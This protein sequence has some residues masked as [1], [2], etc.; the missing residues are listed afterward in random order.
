MADL[1]GVGVPLGL[2]LPKGVL[3]TG[4]SESKEDSSPSRAPPPPNFGQPP[5]GALPHKAK[6]GEAHMVL[7]GN[8][9]NLPEA[10]RTFQDLPGPVGTILVHSGTF[11]DGFGTFR[12]LLE[13][14]QDLLG[15]FSNVS[16]LSG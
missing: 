13:H 15:L 5:W 14:F 12:N 3:P 11:R 7:S 8:L 1:K 10:S 6:G 16:E 4:E 9:W 2:L